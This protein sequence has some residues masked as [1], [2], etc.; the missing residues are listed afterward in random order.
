M[1][2]FVHFEYVKL[3]VPFVSGK[4]AEI[5]M[6]IVCTQSTYS[7]VIQHSESV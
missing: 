2:C 6:P 7:L 3:Q 5:V 1:Q 4:N